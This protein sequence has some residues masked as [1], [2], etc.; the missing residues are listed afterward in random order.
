MLRLRFDV[1]RS[2]A[3]IL[4]ALLGCSDSPE[5]TAPDSG[6]VPVPDATVAVP[7]AAAPPPDAT[8]VPTDIREYLETVDG[9]TI[10]EEL[11]PDIP[12][13]RFFILVYD[14]PSDHA[15][16]AGVRF[17]QRVTLLHRDRAAPMVLMTT[18][19][20]GST[21]PSRAELTRLLDANQIRTE[22]RFFAPS[23]PSPADWTHLTIEQ[24]AAD[25]HRIVEAL[26]PYYSDS[27]WVATGASKGGMTSIYHRRFHPDDLDAVVAYVA[28]LS[29]GEDDP[30]YIAFL[31]EVGDATCR[32]KLKDFQREVLLRREAMLDRVVAS[33][34]ASGYTYDILGL[35]GA[36]EG[37]VIEM[38]FSFWQY[39]DPALCSS[40]P[41]STDSDATLYDWLETVGGVALASDSGIIQFRAY[42]HQAFTQLGYPGIDTSYIDDLLIAPETTAAQYLEPGVDI[43]FDETAMLDVDDWVKTEGSELLFIYGEVDPWSAGAFELGDAVDSHLFVVPGGNHGSNI[44]DLTPSDE[45]AVHDILERWTGVTPMFRALAPGEPVETRFEPRARLMR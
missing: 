33:A 4:V 14:Q 5:A 18:G 30:R 28:P 27:K 36:L 12:G 9:M 37:T 13:Y 23:R 8:P 1:R 2:L 16:P 11:D 15:N 32:Q 44:R 3:A 38:P 39:R 31:D 25:H 20:Y 41:D 7:D 35:D 6:P 24:A 43:T 19:Y 34:E 40:L 17:D 21:R 26:E 42:Y 45:Q 22:Q 10:V 29:F